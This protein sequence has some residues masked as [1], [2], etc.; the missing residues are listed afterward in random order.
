M[1]INRKHIK[2]L[3]S[4]I[5]AL[6]MMT[7]TLVSA[8]AFAQS[9]A[10][11]SPFKFHDLDSGAN[12]NLSFDRERVDAD[13]V[14]ALEFAA[15]EGDEIAMWQLGRHYS[16]GTKGKGNH[17]RA[18]EMFS[19]LVRTQGE[20][21][22]YSDKAPF[23]AHALVSLGSYYRKGIPNTY[24]SRNSDL[25]WSMFMTAATSYGD[26]KAQYSLFEMCAGELIDRCSQV[27][28]GRWLKRSA[29]NGDIIAQA[30]FGYRQ[31]E[32]EK[33]VRRD[34]VKGLTW[35]T[36]AR[37]RAHVARHAQVFD[38]HERAFSLA[39]AEERSE[40]LILAEKWM[41]KKCGNVLTC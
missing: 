25:A 17:L 37:E 32:G 39:S 3:G 12:A 11:D 20:Q 35:L 10:N 34:K 19:R 38:L 13:S 6:A 16:V 30:R 27:Q 5:A 4:S 7:A 33:G 21:T 14:K 23:T 31:F 40:A 26:P 1:R 41:Q 28:A 24:V 8:P 9:S 15:E 22:P 36:I 29:Q 18:F 2:G